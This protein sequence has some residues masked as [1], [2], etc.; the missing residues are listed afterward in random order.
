MFRGSGPTPSDA[1]IDLTRALAHVATIAL[2]QSKAVRDAQ[3][4][5]AQLQQALDSR[6]VIEQAK[7]M[8]AEQVST[9]MDEAF[10]RLRRHAR[11]ANSMLTDTARAV[12]EGSLNA[13]SLEG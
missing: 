9:D 3:L 4:L 2:M 10:A 13:G 7:G 1:D 5:T 12:I 6:V 11:A 8:L